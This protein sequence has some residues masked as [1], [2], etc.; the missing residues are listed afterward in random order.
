MSMLKKMLK[1]TQ[2]VENKNLL[3]TMWKNQYHKGQKAG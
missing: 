2:L 3:A 1:K